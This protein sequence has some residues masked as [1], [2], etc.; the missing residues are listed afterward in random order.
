MAIETLWG[1]VER[2]RPIIIV[3]AGLSVVMLV[4]TLFYPFGYDQAVFSVGG[5]MVLKGA[6]PYRDFLDTKQ[7]LIFYLYAVALWLFGPHEWS[8][9]VLDIFYQLFAAYYFFRILRRELSFEIAL[10]SSSLMLMLYAGSGFWM[11]CEAESFA[12]LPSLLLVDMTQRTVTSK[13]L[14]KDRIAFEYGLIAGVA[15]VWLFVLKLTLV[16]GGFAAMVFVLSR[17][18]ISTKMKW[19]ASIAPTASSLVLGIAS[20]LA[21]WWMGALHPFLQSL[22]W[23]WH[24]SSIGSGESI[25]VQ[26]FLL[27]PERIMYSASIALV[28]LGV[29]GI[30]LNAKRKNTTQPHALLILLLLAGSIQLLGVLVERKIEFPYQYTR[31]LWAFTPFMA[32]GLMAFIHWL[33]KLRKLGGGSRAVV[34]VVCVLCVLLLSPLPRIFTQTIPWAAMAITG[35]D[36]PAEVQ[37]RIPDYFAEDELRVVNYLGS[38]MS[39]KDQLY[40]WG[41]D[42]GI[43]FFSNKLPQT[44]CL[45]ATPFRS[46]FTPP[47]WKAK[48][49]RQLS[50][51]PP[52]YF[53]AEFGDAKP[54]ITGSPLDSYNALLAWG[55]LKT[56]LTTNYHA[57]TTIGHFH[58]FLLNHD[59]GRF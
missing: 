56:F 10:I 14:A 5:E 36:A 38:K 37:R 35:G 43:Y 18:G 33:K 11:T 15:V 46:A 30:I 9:H 48:L 21:L 57:D 41:N 58:I 17:R 22:S 49:L 26:L 34:W 40:F 1:A 6:I 42:V 55:G 4:A 44:I 2:V 24:Y 32:M 12:I 51:A 52:K 19:R 45:T 47:E 16:L 50:E 25:F 20:I 3:L 7:P 54:Y 28:I 39:G 53:I 29:L 8:I 13:R 31:A 59:L 27:F 23:L